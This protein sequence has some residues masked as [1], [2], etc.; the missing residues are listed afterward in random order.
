MGE[1]TSEV[2][3]PYQAYLVRLWQT[4]D[5]AEG[6]WRASVESPHTGEKRWFADLE[7]LFAFLEE[8][9][10]HPREGKNEG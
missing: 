2:R 1:A 10:A 5:T 6:A 8:A 4:G 9:T 3:P 7:A